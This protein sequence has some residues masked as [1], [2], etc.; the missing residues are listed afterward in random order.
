MNPF[1]TINAW[2]ERKP[3]LARNVTVIV[4]CLGAVYATAFAVTVGD[5][6]AGFAAGVLLM[7][8]GCA[9]VHHAEKGR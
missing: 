3:V 7:G 9:L 8:A 4:C 6:G 5:F 2:T 1:K